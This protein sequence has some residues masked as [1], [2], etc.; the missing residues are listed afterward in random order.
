[1]MIPLNAKTALQRWVLPLV[2][3]MTS[4]ALLPAQEEEKKDALELLRTGR[5]AEAEAVCREELQFYTKDQLARRMDSYA[6]LTWA[7]LRQRKYN[8]VIRMGEAGLKETRYDFRLIESLGEAHYYLGHN[9]DS[10]RYFEEYA[11]LMPTGAH[12][13]VVY[14]FMGEIYLRLGQYYHADVAFS[15]AIYH[16]G[17]IARWWTRLGYVREM[18]AEYETALTAYERALELNPSLVEANRGLDRVKAQL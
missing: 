11:S 6:V 14:Y 9:S 1:M 8:E 12:I 4:L 7:L 17:K 2:L 15:T 18:A 5:Y 13:D 3:L 10:L 16:S